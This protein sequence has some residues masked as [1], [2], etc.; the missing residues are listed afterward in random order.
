MEAAPRPTQVPWGSVVAGP[1]VALTSEPAP[2]D[3]AAAAAA[4]AGADGEE[5]EL[6]ASP[7]GL[8]PGCALVQPQVLPRSCPHY[9][10]PRSRT[11]W[12]PRH[13]PLLPPP[14]LPLPQA[15]GPCRRAPPALPR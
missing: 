1:R 3:T 10:L 8:H 2:F 13:T 14:P 9:L 12:T 7:P 6:G 4:V 5:D 11:A 15:P